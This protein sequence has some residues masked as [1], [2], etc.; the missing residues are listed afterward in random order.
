MKTIKLFLV[1]MFALVASAQ[2]A[3]YYGVN[4]DNAQVDV[5]S[6]KAP[7]RE[8]G[9]QLK[10]AYDEYSHPITGS[11]LGGGD[12]IYGMKLPKGAKV[13][14]VILQTPELASASTGCQIFAGILDNGSGVQ[15]ANTTLFTGTSGAECGGADLEHRMS[16]DQT[17]A[18]NGT[19]LAAESQVVLNFENVSNGSANKKIKLWVYYAY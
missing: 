1:G 5:P 12:V 10:V 14:D 2:G 6:T 15:S 16:A 19:V 7:N 13:Y 11:S 4:A 8:G 17:I 18:G 3:T 9:G